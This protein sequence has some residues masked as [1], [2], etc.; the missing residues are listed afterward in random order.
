MTS[1][2]INSPFIVEQ[3]FLSPLI[4][5]QI[6]SDIQVNTPDRD[7]KDD[8][9]KLER[10]APQW[11]HDIASRFQSIVPVIEEKY[12][13]KYKGLTTPTFQYYPE[14]AKSP[15]EQPGCENSKYVR[16]RWVM[17]KDVDLVGFIWLKDFQDRVPLD[18]RHEVFGGKLE[19]PAYNFS[20]VP[21]RGTLIIFPAGPHF[22][23][24]ISP[25]LVGDLY[26]IKLNINISAENGSRW[27]YQPQNHP[28]KWQDW[29]K[30]HF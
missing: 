23:S 1:K 12:T 26:Q 20:L 21:Q 24:A 5:E 25:I 19:F 6:I 14:N 4:C 22:I 17:H 2:K 3:D 30:E 9:I 16:K 28:G 11:H 8:P 7:E 10:H 18:P 27:F 13:A 29:F 15:A